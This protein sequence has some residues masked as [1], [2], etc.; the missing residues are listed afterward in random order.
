MKILIVSTKDKKGGAAR[1]AYRLHEAF[2]KIDVDSRMLVQSKTS[3]DPKVIGPLSRFQQGMS[4]IRPE[5]DKLPLSLYPNKKNSHF[6]SAFFPNKWVIK[7]INESDIDIVHLHWIL[8]GML[9]IE[10]LAKINKPIVW[11]LHDMWA[12]T[13]GCFYDDNCG[14]YISGCQ[15]CPALGSKNKV[16]LSKLIFN[17]KLKT[18]SKIEKINIVGLSRWICDCARRSKLLSMH[19]IINL[20]NPID[21]DIFKPLEKEVARDMLNIPLN[22]KL[23]LFG[24]SNLFDKR[25]GF[26]EILNALPKV[27]QSDVQLIIFGSKAQQNDPIINFRTHY[28]GKLSDDI[29][30]RVLYSSADV[31][32]MPSLQENLSNV[33]MEALACGTPV[34]A[35][36]IGGNSDMIDHVENGYL[37]KPF[38]TNDLAQGIDWVLRNSEEESLSSN[39]RSKVIDN[40]EMQ[41]VAKRYESLYQNII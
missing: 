16:D 2:L 38:E 9:R 8:G 19:P 7:K 12:F 33:I 41:L 22:K 14:K 18:F 30:L 13:G 35:F 39:A 3:K 24:A 15:S 6:S 4:I 27:E 40:F 10:E 5:L 34:V 25:K 20:P 17:R 32:V 36:N 28:I 26:A 29:A 1:A 31:L 23:I 21:T 11:T 37:A